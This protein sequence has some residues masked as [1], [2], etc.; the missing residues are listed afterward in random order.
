[1]GWFEVTE[2]RQEKRKAPK[3]INIRASKSHLFQAPNPEMTSKSTYDALYG[4]ARPNTN[5]G[6][7]TSTSNNAPSSSTIAFTT[8]L[9]S[10]ISNNADSSAST[11]STTTARGRPRPSKTS[12]SDIF[13]KHN[14]G[15]Q[16][17]AARDEAQ[18]EKDNGALRQVHQR[19]EDI[20]T[21][22]AATLSRSKRHLEEKAR[23]Y[24][25]LKSGMH[26][27]VGSDDED[28]DDDIG[29]SGDQQQQH[30]ARL[31]R[32]EREGLVDFDKKWADAERERIKRRKIT[33]GTGSSSGSDYDDD[34]D[35]E[36][37]NTSIISYEDEL[38]RTRH[39]TR[40][41]ASQATRQKQQ[42]QQNQQQQQEAWK[43][44]RPENLIYGPTV[45]SEAFNPSAR[46][47]EQMSHLASRRDRSP[48]PPEPIHYD[49]DS[50]VRTR[51]TGFYAF[52]RD[53]ETRRKEME[54][55]MNVRD[56]T[57]R[58][59]D[60]RSSRRAERERMKNERWKKIEDLRVKRRAENF[61]DALSFGDLSGSGSEALNVV[62]ADG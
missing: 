42:D 41:Q 59:R 25:D 56:E 13:T 50:E 6:Q 39:G 54:E 22:D 16:K 29:P 58:E 26:L 48:T 2:A 44:S 60:A 38:G 11:P 43:P 34:D 30:F 37:D 15:A 52:S 49:P 47:A 18:N 53:E 7:S 55:L 51:G 19:T 17:R 57:L 3:S 23:I 40:K 12:K 9:S 1:M 4:K 62:S 36:E 45:Q 24:E 33:A 28:E 35:E 10:L 61:L 46:I 32:K 5:T 27:A 8:H 31:R 20:G 21:V 14:K